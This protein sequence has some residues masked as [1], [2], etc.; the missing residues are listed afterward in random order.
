MTVFT[1][2]AWRERSRFPRELL[3]AFAADLVA[4]G[5]AVEL[6]DGR[7]A[8]TPR[9]RELRAALSVFADDGDGLRRRRGRHR[10]DE[11]RN[12]RRWYGPGK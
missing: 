2:E 9:G 6:D 7:Y 5:L 4:D 10:E 8:I 1:I 12:R 3:A 11:R